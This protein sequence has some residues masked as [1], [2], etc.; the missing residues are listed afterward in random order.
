MKLEP[1][2]TS[3][4][5]LSQFRFRS[6]QPIL[7]RAALRGIGASLN[8]SIIAL[9]AQHL[10]SIKFGT[11]VPEVDEHFGHNVDQRNE[12]DAEVEGNAIEAQLREE[13]GFTIQMKPLDLAARLKVVRDSCAAELEK[14]AGMRM[15]PITNKLFK[16]P[17]DLVSPISESVSWQLS[18]PVRIDEAVIANTAAVLHLD[19]DSIRIQLERQHQTQQKFLK[20][21]AAELYTIIDNLA[22]KGD[23]GHV[24]GIEDDETVEERLP[25]LNRARL[26]VAADKGLWTQRSREVAAYMRGAPNA[27]GNI[28]LID[29]EREQLHAKFKVLMSKQHIKDEINDAVSRGAR[30]PTLLALFPKVN[31]IK[32]AA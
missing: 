25:A 12:I 8:F 20:D 14:H 15:N 32:Q 27:F 13:Q 31:E 24:M 23:D 30:Q 17:F 29:G 10:R 19:V 22:Y 21:N 11:A 26:Y 7:A 16:N 5:I 28:G 6:D 1:I 4:S 9:A 18:Q 2:T 3:P